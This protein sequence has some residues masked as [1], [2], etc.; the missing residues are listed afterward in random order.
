[1][2]KIEG[3]P[4]EGGERAGMLQETKDTVTHVAE[5]ARETVEEKVRTGLQSRKQK[6]VETAEDVAEAIRR[7]GRRLDEEGPLPMLADRAADG[8]ERIAHYVQDRDLGDFVDE[9]E[10]FARREPAIFIGSAFAIGLL[11]ARFL[12]SSS[13]RAEVD[14]EDEEIEIEAE[15]SPRLEAETFAPKV[16]SSGGRRRRP[17][18]STTRHH[19]RR[20]GR[21]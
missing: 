1:M 2:N 18:A 8:I 13:R 11:G 10:G 14:E 21:V 6:A 16:K 5:R 3:T 9:L 4:E 20:A 17:R 19:H 15:V 12:R 7:S